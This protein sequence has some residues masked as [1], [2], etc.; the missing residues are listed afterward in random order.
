MKTVKCMEKP[1]Y[2][3]VAQWFESISE[4]EWWKYSSM[5]AEKPQKDEYFKKYKS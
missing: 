4:F 2:T 1:N 3:V 5:G